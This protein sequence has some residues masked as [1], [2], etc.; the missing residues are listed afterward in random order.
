M[1]GIVVARKLSK[2]LVYILVEEDCTLTEFENTDCELF[3]AGDYVTGNFQTGGSED[4]YNHTQGLM[5]SGTVQRYGRQPKPI[6]LPYYGLFSS[7]PSE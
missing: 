6:Y 7:L 4:I 5:I 2:D 3:E 1:R